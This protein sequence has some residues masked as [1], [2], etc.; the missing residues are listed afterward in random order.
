MQRI[1]SKGVQGATELLF[2][3]PVIRCLEAA[4]DGCH[5]PKY[6]VVSLKAFR[7]KPESGGTNV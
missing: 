6:S 7:R 5:N 4:I 1:F 3:T 2:E